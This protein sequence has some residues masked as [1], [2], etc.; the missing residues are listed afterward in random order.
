MQQ[1]VETFYTAF[2]NL[3]SETMV[4]CYHDDITFKDPAFGTLKGEKAKNMWR[5]LCKS[6]KGQNF[7]VEASNIESSNGK[8][9]AHW[10]AHYT[11][12][13]TGRKVHNII[14]AEFEFKDGK[15]IK[16]TDNFNLHKWAK[17]AFGFKGFILGGTNFFKKKLQS[18]TNHLLSKFEI[19]SAKN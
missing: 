9:T 3:D 13:K 12:S 17:Q 10:E 16:H 19:N 8:V 15:I 14:D 18:Q 2:K 5:M 4:S 6:Q 11:F 1:L 7:V